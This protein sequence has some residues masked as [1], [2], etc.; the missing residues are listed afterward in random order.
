MYCRKCGKELDANSNFCQHCGAPNNESQNSSNPTQTE[1]SKKPKKPVYKRWWFWVLIALIALASCVPKSE[2]PEETTLS[3]ISTTEEVLET[4]EATA[5]DPS[6]TT[7]TI[8]IYTAAALIESFVKDNFENY[9]IS[10]EENT[11]TVSLWMDGLAKNAVL[12]ASGNAEAQESWNSVV[13]GTQSYSTTTSE[14]VDSLGL[15]DV[16]VVVNILN[17]Q[18]TENVLL[19]VINGVVIYD[20]VSGQ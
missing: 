20:S 19:S 17:D 5:S 15:D 1:K 8:D 16:V 7:L 4:S 3:T 6:E 2:V 10:C 9:N 18:N 14:T 12:A 11:I 13:E